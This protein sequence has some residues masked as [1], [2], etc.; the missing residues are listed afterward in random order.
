[1]LPPPA[2]GTGGEPPAKK[3]KGDGGKGVNPAPQ[4]KAAS[5]MG[6]QQ[7]SWGSLPTP[8]TGARGKAM[9][10][11]GPGMPQ[12][13][14]PVKAPGPG[15]GFPPSPASSSTASAFTQLLQQSEAQFNAFIGGAN[16]GMMP[17]DGGNAQAGS[18]VNNMAAQLLRDEDAIRQ[19]QEDAQQ[20][21]AYRQQQEEMRKLQ[22]EE[23][24][25][26]IE[27]LRLETERRKEL[28]EEE[29]KL[30]QAELEGFVGVLE[31]KGKAAQELAEPLTAVAKDAKPGQ[32]LAGM[33]D[34]QIIAVADSFEI[35]RLAAAEALKECTKFTA[36]KHKKLAGHKEQT[37]KIAAE[38][39]SR[40]SKIDRELQGTNAKV[41]LQ[42]K[43]AEQRKLAAERK[44]AARK[45]AERLDALFKKHDAN[46]DGKLEADD[47]IALCK[48]EY[49]FVLEGDRLESLKNGV[50]YKADSGVTL[51][52]Y[53]QL[54]TFLGVARSEILAKRRAEERIRAQKVAKGQ[55]ENIK[56]NFGSV[57][58][59][60][61]GIEV[62]V[63]KAERAGI[64]LNSFKM[65]GLPP[66]AEAILDAVDTAI[67]A[68]RDYMAVAKEQVEQ[69]AGPDAK[70]EVEA[71]N[72]LNK[73]A[74]GVSHRMKQFE[75]R[76]ERVGG[77]AKTGR[78]KL[79]LQQRKEALLRA[80]SELEAAQ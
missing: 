28:E 18:G 39:I 5:A 10:P 2:F 64:P 41:S 13:F 46:G 73:T 60:I 9:A 3:L 62:E 48:E 53:G 55:I 80:A 37:K 27:R 49:D 74:L 32:P 23:R 24:K 42:K 52:K 54:R 58:E 30:I 25:L 45:E 67:E 70:L 26:E 17:P 34:A 15:L 47:I 79:E 38:L 65:R 68:A 14:V 20:H 61:A 12:P 36:G 59:C 4:S 29:A 22:E 56:K 7:A 33:D 35:A 69:L 43:Q 76:L 77:L 21:E 19:A 71:Q 6:A 8:P 78:G 66:N 72:V 31:I 44:E 11:T 50:V 40:V 51:A 57:T 75:A 16:Q 63:A 1:M